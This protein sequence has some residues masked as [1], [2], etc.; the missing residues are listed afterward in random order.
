MPRGWHRRIGRTP[1]F[2]STII[3]GASPL[4]SMPHLYGYDVSESAA[5]DFVARP[6]AKSHP[7]DRYVKQLRRRGQRA[8]NRKGDR[9]G[10]GSS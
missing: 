10:R 4:G 2:T 6:P 5:V 3:A 9:V 7:G 1:L 8:S